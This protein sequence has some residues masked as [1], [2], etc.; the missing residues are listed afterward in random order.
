MN[1]HE[2]M[3]TTYSAQI[4]YRAGYHECNAERRCRIVRGV[5]YSYLEATL[6]KAAYRSGGAFKN[7]Y[8]WFCLRWLTAPIFMRFVAFERKSYS[9][10][11]EIDRPTHETSVKFPGRQLKIHSW[12]WDQNLL[13]ANLGETGWEPLTWWGRGG[14][15]QPKF[16]DHRKTG[17][18]MHQILT[19]S[20]LQRGT[21]VQ[22]FG[23]NG[24]CW[25]WVLGERGRREYTRVLALKFAYEICGRLSM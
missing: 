3:M 6:S 9:F 22:H 5:R 25:C 1:L 20:F 21:W 13:Q 12:I 8:T 18:K 10:C 4:F 19:F 23:L 24:E 7:H 17:P 16:Y 11:V 14:K 2:M 15:F